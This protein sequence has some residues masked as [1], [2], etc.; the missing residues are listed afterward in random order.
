MGTL[1]CTHKNDVTEM[2]FEGR[3]V[4][5]EFEVKVGVE[6][7]FGCTGTP[8]RD[9]EDCWVTNMVLGTDGISRN[10]THGVYR[11]MKGLF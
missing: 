11:G 3:V 2:S 10:T 4:H 1:F 5:Y 7:V 8:R 9:E 6:E